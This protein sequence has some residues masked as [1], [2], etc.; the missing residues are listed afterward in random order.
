ML[1]NGSVYSQAH[2]LE[3]TGLESYFGTVVI[4]GTYGINKPDKRIYEIICAKLQAKPQD[5]V[6]IGDGLVN[7][8]QGSL[9][10]GMRSVWI[11]PDPKCDTNLPCQRIFT[12]NDLKQLF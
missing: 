9:Q 10:A 4:S 3:Q 8:V 1:T 12:I 5:C 6:Y 11:Y 2:K 7:D